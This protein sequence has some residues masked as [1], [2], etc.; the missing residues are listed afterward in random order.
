[1]NITN[2]N[3]VRVVTENCYSQS[4]LPET[5]HHAENR[6]MWKKGELIQIVNFPGGSLYLAIPLYMEPDS[7]EAKRFGNQLHIWKREFR[8]L[9][10]EELNF[11]KLDQPGTKISKETRNI[12]FM[13][14]I[15]K[16]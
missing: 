12:A 5:Y 7:T 4:L 16:V 6:L 8:E 9:T 11:L 3:M 14:P 13:N 10:Q 1:M 2:L 15:I